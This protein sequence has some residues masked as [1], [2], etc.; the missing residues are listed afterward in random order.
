MFLGIDTLGWMFIGGVFCVIAL[1][2]AAGLAE[3]HEKGRNE[4]TLDSLYG[5]VG[6][7]DPR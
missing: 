7:H 4:E 6:G 5:N 2:I 3:K 1:P